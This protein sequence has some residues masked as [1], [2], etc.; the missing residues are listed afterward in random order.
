MIYYDLEMMLIEMSVSCD[1]SWLRVSEDME[2]G[3]RANYL[4]VAWIPRL[5]VT[6]GD[7]KWG[8]ATTF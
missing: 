8:Y 4:S 1:R 3:W 2:D 7:V 5:L 6:Q